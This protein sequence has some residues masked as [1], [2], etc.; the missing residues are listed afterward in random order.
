MIPEH[1]C[2]EWTGCKDRAGYGIFGIC[3]NKKGVAKK[4][5]RISWELKNGP[6]IN[7]LFVLHKCDNPG[8]I[9][10]EHLF[11]GTQQDNVRDCSNKGRISRGSN[12]PASKLTGEQVLEIRKIHKNGS[13]TYTKTSRQFNVSETLIRTIVSRKWWRHI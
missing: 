12:R 1:S 4:A 8:C 7:G 13:K 10:P 3:I 9:R 5:S 2:W 6:I 11:L